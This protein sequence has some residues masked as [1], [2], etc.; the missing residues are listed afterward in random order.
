MDSRLRLSRYAYAVVAWL[1]VVGILTQVFL[2]G[3]S[4]LGRQPS[5]PIHIGLGHTL[6]LLALLLVAL[7]YVGALPHPFKRLTW[8]VFALYILLAD[9][10]IFLRESVPVVAALHP[11]L[12]VTLFAITSSLAL[13]AWRLVREART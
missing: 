3:L 13:R 2:V 5:W 1:F 7:T 10:V 12:A 9:V 6:G 11:V 8:V 4:L